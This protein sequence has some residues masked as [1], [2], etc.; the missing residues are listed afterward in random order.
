MS[1]APYLCSSN[2]LVLKP[3]IIVVGGNTKLAKIIINRHVY[4]K[5]S[6][7]KNVARGLI[8]QLCG[9][10]SELKFQFIIPDSNCYDFSN[11]FNI[12]IKK[13]K[14]FGG[15]IPALPELRKGLASHH[16]NRFVFLICVIRSFTQS[17]CE[18]NYIA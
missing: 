17:K 15:A 6:L 16:I 2:Q 18:L 14:L 8:G 10:N 4:K 3:Y 1:K 11:F 7:P 12:L 13:R 9:I 5:R